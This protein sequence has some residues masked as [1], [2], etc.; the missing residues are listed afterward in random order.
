MIAGVDL[1]CGIGG[2]THGL[3]NAGIN[4]K[5]GVDIDPACEFSYEANNKSQFIHRDVSKLTGTEIKQLWG[6]AKITL[7]AGCAPCQPFSSY[8]RSSRKSKPNQKW[9][10]LNSTIANC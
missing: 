1:F 4:I 2:L 5:A 6:N 10:T 7:L 9:E 3:Q 8:S